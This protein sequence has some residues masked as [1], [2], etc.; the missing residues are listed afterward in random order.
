[1]TD[2]NRIPGPLPLARQVQHAWLTAGAAWKRAQA[3]TEDA[4][5]LHLVAASGHAAMA[6]DPDPL[7]FFLLPAEGSDERAELEAEAATI[8]GDLPRARL[9]S[10]RVVDYRGDPGSE[11]DICQLVLDGK[12]YGPRLRGN[13]LRVARAVL[14]QFAMRTATRE[15]SPVSYGKW[16]PK[17]SAKAIAAVAADL[18]KRYPDVFERRTLAEDDTRK[19]VALKCGLTVRL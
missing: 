18:S 16:E 6:I 8:D 12:D 14:D 9:V 3:L 13:H 4:Q 5:G 1:M 19:G 7:L 17:L 10:L 2:D 11:H 15:P